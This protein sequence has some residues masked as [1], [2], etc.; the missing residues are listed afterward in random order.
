MKVIA[1]SLLK[2][3]ML[4]CC[5]LAAHCLEGAIITADTNIPRAGQ[6][7]TLQAAYDAAQSGDT[8][9]L[10]PSNVPYQG[11]TVEKEV[12]I[13]GVGWMPENYNGVSIKATLINGSMH[14]GTGSQNSSIEG[15]GG[16]FQLTVNAPNIIVRKCKIL[17]MSFGENCQSLLLL[18]NHIVINTTIDSYPSTTYTMA[19]S[20]MNVDTWNSL[21]IFAILNRNCNFFNN[22]LTYGLHTWIPW[23]GEATFL[24]NLTYRWWLE[25]SDIS[26][27]N[28]EICCNGWMANSDGSLPDGSPAIDAGSPDPMFNDLD[29]TR[30][31]IGPFGGGTPFVAGGIPSMPTIYEI[32]GPMHASPESGIDLIIKVKTNRD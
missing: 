31:D 6:F 27:Y 14:F 17:N 30:N 32:S 2:V 7:A 10:F 21:N 4:F 3:F 29:G 13:L 23:T 11:I 26:M 19:N 28:L 8:I 5:L 20:I 15:F 1:I 22:F 9:H 12:H 24:N 18:Q 16:N 25:S